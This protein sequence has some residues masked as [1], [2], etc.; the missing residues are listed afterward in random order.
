MTVFAIVLLGLVVAAKDKEEIT[1]VINICGEL[2]DFILEKIE[3]LAWV[4]GLDFLTQFKGKISSENYR[5]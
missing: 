5:F 3:V 1:Q 2:V 4:T